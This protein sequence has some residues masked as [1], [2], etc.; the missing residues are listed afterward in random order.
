L[1]ERMVD[2]LMAEKYLD[3]HYG[4]TFFGMFRA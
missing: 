1:V 2:V 4:A 3:R